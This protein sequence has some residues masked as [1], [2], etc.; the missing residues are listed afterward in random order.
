MDLYVRRLSPTAAQFR[1]QRVRQAY[2]EFARPRVMLVELMLAPVLAWL[3]V[4]RRWGVVGVA[5]GASIA[6]A[7]F[8]RRRAGGARYFRWTAS[9]CAPLWL[10]E[11][12]VCAWLAAWQRVRHGGVRYRGHVLR[13]AANSMSTLR[14]RMGSA[15]DVA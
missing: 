11:R 6:V 7:E 5:A 15:R 14:G 3:V 4:R 13:R 12:G 8:G 1:S 9:L 10:L 2:D